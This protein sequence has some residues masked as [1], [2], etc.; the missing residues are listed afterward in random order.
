[1]NGTGHK[2][3]LSL[4]FYS[5]K[6]FFSRIRNILRFVK[7]TIC[8]DVMALRCLDAIG[9]VKTNTCESQQNNDENITTLE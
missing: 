9:A 4:L 2:N 3:S 8:A 6:D 7:R 1:M 5:L